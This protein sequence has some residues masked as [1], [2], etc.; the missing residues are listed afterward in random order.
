M[1]KSLNYRFPYLP[2][3]LIAI[4]LLHWNANKED[5]AQMPVDWLALAHE[6]GHFVYWNS[7]KLTDYRQVQE[8]FK[9]AVDQQIRDYFKQHPGSDEAIIEAACQT[10]Q[11]WLEESF[12]D[13]FGALVGGPAYAQNP[14]SAG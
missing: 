9:T 2:A 14:R 6:L 10:W 13:L 12:A 1:A 3:P 11:R 4:P 5:E 8:R 7:A